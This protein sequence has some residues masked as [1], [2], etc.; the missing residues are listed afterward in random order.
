MNVSKTNYKEEQLERPERKKFDKKKKPRRLNRTPRFLVELPEVI[1]YKDIATL[2]KL[3]SERGKILSRR[4]TGVNAKN[5]RLLCEAI[6]RA[7]FLGLLP[8][9]SAKR[10]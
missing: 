9:G 1:D 6:K 10:K 7:R 4:F 3:L 5:Q 2:R 8:V